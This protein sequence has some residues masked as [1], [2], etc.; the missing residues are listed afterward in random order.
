M[1]VTEHERNLS[2][3]ERFATFSPAIWASAPID[4]IRLGLVDGFMF[5]DTFV[6]LPTGRYTITAETTG[7]FLLG[8][9]ANGNG[10]ADAAGVATAGDG[11]TVQLDAAG[12]S[13]FTPANNTKIWF[14][15]RVRALD[16]ATGPQFFLGL[17]EN[18]ITLID[19]GATPANT[20]ANHIGW[21]STTDD[22]ILLFFGE[23]AGT[24]NAAL[25]SPHTLV[26]GDVTTDGTEWVKLGFVVTDLDATGTADLLVEHYVDNVK[27]ATTVT[28]LNVPVLGLKPSLVCQTDATTD[29]IVHID[30]WRVA[31]LN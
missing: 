18:D 10:I 22:A 2:A 20:S 29:S 26:D 31:Q 1:L 6:D 9:V 12:G 23:K 14:E 27:Q 8:D 24:R 3:A 19:G 5:E 25:S 4:Q 13:S 15:A 11:V 7:T 17:S 21:E 30:W 16:I 28:N